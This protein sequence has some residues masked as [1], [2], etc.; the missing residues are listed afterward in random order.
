MIVILKDEVVG[1]S[2][3]IPI[4]I[5]ISVSVKFTLTSIANSQIIDCEFL[6][7]KEYKAKLK[8]DPL[9]GDEFYFI[10][11]ENSSKI[12]KFDKYVIDKH[13]YI[14]TEKQIHQEKFDKKMD[15]ILK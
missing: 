13:F 14:K 4:M 7:G 2:L 5:G 10:K 12:F 8:K 6:R 3:R 11:P 15:K 1:K 9:I